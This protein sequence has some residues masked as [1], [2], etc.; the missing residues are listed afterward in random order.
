M[1]KLNLKEYW[2]EWLGT[3]FLAIGFLIAVL[4][5][6]ADFVYLIAILGGFIAGRNL[7][8]KKMKEPILPF[9]IVTVTFVV[10]FV[11]G[12][13]GA[14]RRTTLLLVVL[15]TIISYYLHREN[16]ITIFKSRDFLK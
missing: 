13:F 8:I 10:G 9:V 6:S 2:V 12:A 16:I 11:L 1:M 5:D 3:L 4:L 15:S 14:E 7:Y